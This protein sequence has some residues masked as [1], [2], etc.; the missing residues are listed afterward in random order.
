MNRIKEHS[1]VLRAAAF[2]VSAAMGL[3][4]AP[5]A[6]LAQDVATNDPA[7]TEVLDSPAALDAVLA[8]QN[9]ASEE[10]SQQKY[11]KRPPPAEVFAYDM[12][13]GPNDGVGDDFYEAY[14]DVIQLPEIDWLR[15][16]FAD[17]DLGQ[18]SYIEIT[19]LKDGGVQ[20]LDSR[21][22]RY[23]YDS[24]AFFNGDAVEIVLVVAPG[25]R[26]VFFR[27]AGVLGGNWIEF[28][29][30]SQVGEPGPATSL[31]GADNRVVSS[32]SR[33]GRVTYLNGASLSPGCTGWLVANG[34]VLTAG[35]CVDFDPDAT[36]ASCGPLLPDGVVE[37][38]FLNGV[39]EFNVPN[40]LSNG[41]P[42][43]SAPQNQFPVNSVSAFNF[44][45]CG[46]GLGKDFA[47]YRI[48]PNT[49]TGENAH[50]GRGFFRVTR[51]NPAAGN[52]IRITGYGT[53]STP[54][55][56]SG[57]R[58]AQNQTNQTS[59]GPYVDE[60]V[61][62][63]GIR[64]RYQTDTTGGNSGSPIIWNSNG[65]TIGIHTNAGCASNGSG[66]NSG[67]SFEHNPLEGGLDN[68]PGSTTVYVDDGHVSNLENGTIYQ[69]FN[70][71]SEG[72][73]LV[74]NNGILCI[75]E[76]TYTAAEGNVLTMG[77]DGKA[78]GIITPVGTVTI[79]N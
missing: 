68:F 21:S 32:D 25:D 79:G 4:C 54:P 27:L 62:A 14:V 63:D 72:V 67:T 71:V 73:N 34:A 74:V 12:D 49:G 60:V 52:T 30:V 31:C 35:H 47:V 17:Y 7:L 39:L 11:V 18:R 36:S 75:V 13:T 37:T 50:V 70:L 16:W 38:S 8:M 55:G 48:N 59:T 28:P 24:S 10:E 61:S 5:I 69:P 56:S 43:L 23:W 29:Y 3:L 64:H 76:G 20:R 15:V 26:G 45:G 65:L 33:V 46:Q 41:T 51:S 44:D 42:V 66:A 19:S 53:D 58:N 22:I 6:A 9:T 2:A 78:M 1:R 40:S 77:A 57:G